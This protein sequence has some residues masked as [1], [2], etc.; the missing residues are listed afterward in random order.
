MPKAMSFVWVLVLGLAACEPEPDRLDQAA[1]PGH[2]D[3]ILPMEEM[4]SR[5]RSR[6][7]SVDTLS[8]ASASQ[9][10][11][12]QRFLAAIAA[13]DS[14]ELITM[15]VNPQEFAWLIFPQHTYREPPYE[16]DP[17]VL[18]MQLQQGSMKG[19]GRV[20]ERHGGQKLS[21]RAMDC[22]ADTLQLGEGPGKLWGPC[23]LQYSTPDSTLTRQLFGSIYELDGR[24]KLL[25]YNN[26]F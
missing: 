25:S 20:L 17:A 8:G 10:E 6:M 4:E 12:A 1:M 7:P 19:V 2:V 11:L 23:L 13:H 24:F 18:W 5:F 3:S 9:N 15:S 21:F 26:D 14:T 22:P 16:L